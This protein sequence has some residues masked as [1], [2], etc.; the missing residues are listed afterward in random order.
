MVSLY[1]R[2]PLGRI[3]LV[4]ALV[5]LAIGAVAWAGGFFDRD[6]FHFLKAEGRRG[7][8]AALYFSG[9]M[10]LRFGMGPKTTAALARHGVP[11][12]GV[13]SSTLFAVHHDR[14]YVD[15]VVADAARRALAETG[16]RKLVLIG[17][18]YGADI[19]QTGAAA[20]PADLRPKVAAIILV[21]P[22]RTV[23]FRAD[24]SGIA[25]R[26]TPDSLGP[27]TAAALTWAPLTCIYGTAE[28]DSLCPLVK[29]PN[30]TVVAMPGGHFLAHDEAALVGHVLASLRHFLP[31]REHGA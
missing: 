28:T 22:G 6:P 9:D 8:V 14:A 13:S 30:A 21:V 26:G 2:R 25:Y 19:L 31:A 11:V 29:L 17:Q 24:P 1:L 18:S 12:L 16:A 20:L 7:D 23:F 3:A 5:V 4:A 27:A 15:K 10:G